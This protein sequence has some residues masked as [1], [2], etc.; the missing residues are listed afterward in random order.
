MDRAKAKHI[1]DTMR[2][3]MKEWREASRTAT[4]ASVGG[5]LPGSPSKALTTRVHTAADFQDSLHNSS[6]GHNNSSS[7]SSGGGRHN[8][9]FSSAEL[10]Q[11]KLRRPKAI[12]FSQHDTD[13]QGVGHFLYT[14][15]GDS[16]ICEHF[17]AYQS[18]ELSRFRHSARK[19]RR[20]PVCGYCN[21]VADERNC[22]QVLLMVEYLDVEAPPADVV[23]P[24]ER[25]GHGAAGPGGHYTGLCLCSPTGCGTKSCGGTKNAFRDGENM[26]GPN[27]ALIQNEDVHGWELGS[28]FFTAGQI[29]YVKSRPAVDPSAEPALFRDTPLLWRGGIMGGRAAVRF[30]RKCGGKDKNISWHGEGGLKKVDWQVEAEPACILLLKEDGSTGLDLSFATHIFLLERIKDPA[31][32]SQIV[33]RAHRMGATGPVQVQLI[34]VQSSMDGEVEEEED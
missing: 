23:Y 4:R 19:F 21:S 26:L 22:A 29:I 9:K 28:P 15:L 6:G 1:A 27:C 14:D 16:Y 7:S 31:L 30:W 18:V 20:C 24:P 32:R 34:Q 2:A 25:A 5:A 13:L 17:G 10:T 11:F 8:P 12:V 3:A 33:S